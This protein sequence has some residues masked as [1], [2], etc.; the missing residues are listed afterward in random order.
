[1]SHKTTYRAF[2]NPDLSGLE[3]QVNDFIRSMH[4]N[5]NH[6]AIKILDITTFTM[7]DNF[8]AAITY[9][10]LKKKQPGVDVPSELS[11]DS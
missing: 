10:Y 11:A 6:E 8:I 4:K 5:E 7:K 9:S 3:T 1:M 2:S